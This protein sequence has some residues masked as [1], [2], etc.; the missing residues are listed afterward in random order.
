MKILVT[1]GQGMV[2]SAFSD[3]KVSGHSDHEIILANRNFADL[4]VYSQFK[5]VL[6]AYKPDAVIHLAA[7]VGGVKGNTDYVHNFYS[8]NAR[9]NCNVLDA[10]Q[11][12][13]IRSVVSLLS[14][15][16]Y[17]DKV[18]YPLTEDQIHNGEPHQSNFGYAYAKRML[19]VHSRAIRQQHGLNYI[20]AVPNNIYG[21]NDNFDLDNGHVIPAVV[22]KIWEAKK[23]G[24]PPS[25]W[26][27]G[28]ALR[29]FTYSTD[30]ALDL[31]SLLDENYDSDVPVNIGTNEEISIKQLVEYVCEI[32]SY[33]GE[34]V[35][36]TSMPAGQFRKPSS[37]ARFKEHVSLR[38]EQ[39]YIS[40]RDGLDDMCKWFS[41]NVPNVRGY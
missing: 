31:L 22:R 13:G 38:R 29:E 14:T 5:N 1:G 17:P 19:D 35:W 6:E 34:V 32:L 12:A 7:L 4:T 27:D 3:P 21:V 11:S 39:E 18:T 16:V 33:E 28:S 23:S 15:C 8:V 20:C 2:G 10:C 41:N 36:D 37:N 9:I 30:I 26:G 40:V 24:I 25:F